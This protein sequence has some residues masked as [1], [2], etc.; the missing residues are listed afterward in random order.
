MGNCAI[1]SLATCIPS[2]VGRPI[3]QM[4]ASGG[5]CTADLTPVWPS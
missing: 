1:N 3:S 2:S 5:C 4:T